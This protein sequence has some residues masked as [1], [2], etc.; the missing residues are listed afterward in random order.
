[1]ADADVQRQRSCTLE[2]PEIE[3]REHHDDSD[4]YQQTRPEMVPEEQHVH[5]NHDGYH[6]EHEKH[7]GRLFSSGQVLRRAAEVRKRR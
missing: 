3:R 1:V 7:D 4:V 2:E 5:A 6:R